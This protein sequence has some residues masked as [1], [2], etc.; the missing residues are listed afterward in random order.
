MAWVA[1]NG[2][3][4]WVIVLSGELSMTSVLAEPDELDEPDEPEL[5]APQA[6]TPAVRR[7]AAVTAASVLGPGNLGIICRFLSSNGRWPPDF[8][9]TG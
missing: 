3:N 8:C 2:L 6:A 1:M 4:A 5:L 9:A 7:A